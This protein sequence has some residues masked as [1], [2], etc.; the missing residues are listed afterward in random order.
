MKNLSSLERRLPISAL[1]IGCGSFGVHLKRHLEQRVE[2]LLVVAG[3]KAPFPDLNSFDAIFLATNDSSLESL[4]LEIRS[5]AP[6]AKIFHFSGFHFF[7]DSLGLHPVAS[8]N[9][10][11]KYNLDEITFVADGDVEEDIKKL[12]PITRSIDPLKKQK[13]HSF[14]SVTANSLQLIVNNIGKDFRDSLDM[15]PDLLKKIVIQSL[16]AELEKGETS[17]SGPWVRGEKEL[18][19]KTVEKMKS[20]SLNNLNELFKCEIKIYKDK[21]QTKNG[22]KL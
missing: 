20:E 17:F 10:E 18:Q 22:G 1:Q 19:N 5:K 15:K 3:R 4:I 16:Q 2:K 9:K 11:S 14:L 8:F 6:K 21:E 7:K 13:Y 12:F